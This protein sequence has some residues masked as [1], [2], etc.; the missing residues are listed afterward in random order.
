LPRWEL[1]FARLEK[2]LA[3]KK[4]VDEKRMESDLRDWDAAWTRKSDIYP[5]TPSGGAVA[6]SARLWS[7]YGRLA[8]GELDGKSLTTGKPATCSASLPPYPASLANDG[9]IWPTDRYWATDVNVDKAAWWQ[10][11]LQQPT[12]VGRV[13]IVFYYGDGRHYGFTLEGS[14]DG[15]TWE[16]LGD[17]RDN[18]EPSTRQGITCRFP[19]R[20]V[21]YLRVTVPHNS[22]NTGRHLVE[23][24]AFEN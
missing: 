17:R 6:I 15:K 24:M 2:S 7:K 5:D 22:A 12:T 10:V 18:K 21:R 19:P 16:M 20:P 8:V 11:D 14:L 3:E 1:F 4:P 9:R 23:V 13:V